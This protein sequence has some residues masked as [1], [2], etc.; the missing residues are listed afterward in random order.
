MTKKLTP[1]PPSHHAAYSFEPLT[2]TRAKPVAPES[3]GQ[4]SLFAI[5]PG[6]NAY[7]ALTQV[8]RLLEAAQLNGDELSLHTDPFERSLFWSLLHSLEMARAVVD[9]LLE[10]ALVPGQRSPVA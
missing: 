10:G 1:D 7:D 2:T 4:P 8:S 6:V 5:Q 3:C 9:S